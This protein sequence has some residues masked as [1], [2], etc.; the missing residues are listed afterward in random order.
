MSKDKNGF[1]KEAINTVVGKDTVLN[2]HFEVRDGIR[3]DGTL[4]GQLESSGML[5]IG[6]SGRVEADPIRVRDAVIAGELVGKLEAAGQV[7]L[8]ASA[9]LVGDIRARVLIIEEGA[10][11]RGLCEAGESEPAVD[12]GTAEEIN[13]EKAVG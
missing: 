13:A 6:P 9:V 8:E 11:L 2:G 7:K 3:V 10:V 5:V 4:R 12:A 1:S